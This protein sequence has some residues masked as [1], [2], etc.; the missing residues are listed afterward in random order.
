MLEFKFLKEW[1]TPRADFWAPS[2]GY[3]EL[4]LFYL[5]LLIEK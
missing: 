3:I 4:L 5:A 2:E 1:N